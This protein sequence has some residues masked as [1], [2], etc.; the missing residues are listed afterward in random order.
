MTILRFLAQWL[1][2]SV[3]LSLAIVGPVL[4]DGQEDVARQMILERYPE[5]DPATIFPSPVSG[6]Y[7]VS[8]G[9]R[10]SYVS[11]DG[12]FLLQGDI[13]DA[14]SEENLT[15]VR[16][17]E[18]RIAALDE[19]GES[20]MIIFEP[21][22]FKHTITVFTDIDCGYCRKLHQ[23]IEVYNDFGFRVRYVFFP[24]SGPDTE[25]WFKAENVWCSEDRNTALTWA[26]N[27]RNIEA[28]DCESTPVEQHYELGLAFG[29]RG[30]PAIVIAETGE[31]IGGYVPP[32]E[33]A[34]HLENQ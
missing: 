2:V 29:I 23:Q 6:L 24:R 17:T 30:T 4:A 27:G 20:S 26:K 3:W 5:L 21:E 32:D 10:I 13:F 19:I 34:E 31:L 9:A 16:R 14:E 1:T 15:E 33:L 11:A 28:E 8:L 25:S 12:A 22:Q 7:E 18:V